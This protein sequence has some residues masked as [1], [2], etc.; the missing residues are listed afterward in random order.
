MINVLLVDDEEIVCRGMMKFINWE[1]YG[2]EVK[3]FARNAADC[4]AILRTIPIN[5]VFLDINMP[6][7]SGLDILPEIKLAYPDIYCVILSGYSDFAYV[8]QALQLGVYDYL[9]KPV[10]HESLENLLTNLREDINEREAASQMEY[11][12]KKALLLS[13]AKGMIHGSCKDYNINLPEKYIGLMARRNIKERTNHELQAS[14]NVFINTISELIPQ[15]IILEDDSLSL[16]VILPLEGTSDAAT[17][18]DSITSN[19]YGEDWF[20]GYSTTIETQDVHR[21]WEEANA[22]M[23]YAGAREVM[24]PICYGNIS[25]IVAP[26]E[27]NTD[28]IVEKMVEIMLKDKSL[29]RP[30]LGDT[31]STLQELIPDIHV[32]QAY[33]IRLSIEAFGRL[34]VYGFKNP[35]SHERFNNNLSRILNCKTENEMTETIIAF[36]EWAAGAAFEDNEKDLSTE[37]VKEIQLY[38]CANYMKSISLKVLAEKF[39]LHPNYLSAVFKEKSGKNYIEYLTE[40]RIAKAKELLKNRSL[41]VWEVSQMVGYDNPRYFG[42]LFKQSTGFTCNDYRNSINQ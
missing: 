15:S 33:I 16:F 13:I 39:Y 38:I 36:F 37:V 14:M 22:A 41:H 24:S 42:Q 19:E 40:I 2:F 31:L 9:N 11:Q 20:F 17:I 21:A 28:E 4:M 25:P 10:P 27:I 7:K 6:D 3:A 34:A 30:F 5:V 29:I 35:T 32:F 18:V 1:D 23:R 12:R 26:R 8:R